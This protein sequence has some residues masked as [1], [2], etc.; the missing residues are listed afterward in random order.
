MTELHDWGTGEAPKPPRSFPKDKRPPGWLIFPETLDDLMQR[1]GPYADA[2]K[3]HLEWSA[4]A[5]WIMKDGSK[6]LQTAGISAAIASVSVLLVKAADEHAAGWPSLCGKIV[7]PAIYGYSS[8]SQRE[9]RRSAAEIYAI[10][11]ANGRPYLRASDCK[12][13]FQYLAACVREG[14]I[15]PIATLSAISPPN[16]QGNQ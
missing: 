5:I 7:T 4:V 8:D 10:W 14:I 13:G 1:A 3:A 16:S 12:L 11:E 6:A 9:A 2:V 15:P